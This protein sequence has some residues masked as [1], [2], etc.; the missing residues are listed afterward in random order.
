MN[1]KIL[2]FLLEEEESGRIDYDISYRGGHYGLKAE[3]VV[4]FLFAG[5]SEE[6]KSQFIEWLPNKVGASCNYLGGGLRGAITGSDYD[7]ELPGY[8]AKLIDKFCAE[9]KNRYNE[10]ENSTGLN[11]EEYEDGET[12][13]DA[14]GSNASRLA[15]IVSAC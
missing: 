6:I 15:G 9:C 8:A 2:S 12:N 11:E 7:R 3:A 14:I 10:I 13:W 4:D 5:K 1:K